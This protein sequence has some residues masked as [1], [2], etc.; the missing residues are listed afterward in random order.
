M[1]LVLTLAIP[2][3]DVKQP[4]K[5]LVG[6][7]GDLRGILDAPVEELR[8]VDGIGSVTPVALRIIRAVAAIYLQQTAEGRDSLA[9][10]TLLADFWRLR[11]GSLANEVFEVACLNS[12]YRLLPD[13]I[14]TL[15]EG[16]IDRATVYPRRVIELALKRGAA[17]L[18]LA[19]NHPNGSVQPSDQDRLLT[20]ALML[21]AE[22]VQ[23]KVHDHLIVSADESFSFRKA[24]LL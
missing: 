11:I 24:G 6:R 3:S 12:A 2:R 18:V 13:G 5:A 20:R 14:A 10:P 9:D 23:L 22:I 1:E 7:F 19:H 21:A 16:T 15:A 17:A 8:T 4:A